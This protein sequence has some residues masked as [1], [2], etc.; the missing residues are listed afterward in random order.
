MALSTTFS[1]AMARPRTGLGILADLSAANLSAGFAAVLIYT[2]GPIPFYV[3]TASQLDPGGPAAVNGLFVAFATAGIGTIVLSLAFK[4]PLAIGWSMPGLIYMATVAPG[5]TLGEIVGANVLASLVIAVLGVSGLARRIT[6]AIPLSVVM[7]M[8]GGTM[9]A[10]C[11]SAVSAVEAAPLVAAP[12][13]AGYFAA[14]A[15]GKGWLPPV[16]GALLVGVPA[17]VLLGEAGAMGVHPGLP[18]LEPVGPSVN[19]GAIVPIAGPLVI[20]SLVGNAQGIAVLEANGYRT[21]IRA[22]TNM[23]AAMSLV[24]ALFAAPPASLQRAALATVAG[25]DAGEPR[26]RYIAAIVAS[27][28]AIALAFTATSATSFTSALPPEFMAVLVGLIM[29]TVALDAVRK[30]VGGTAPMAGFI[31]FAV[32]ASDVNAFGLGSAC[33]A[34]VA[35]VVAH[36]ALE[37][38]GRL[39][40]SRP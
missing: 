14:R 30:T 6:S 7:G 22:I 11:T 32:A 15:L 33:W 38:E 17:L 34:V 8:L 12:P 26:G 35:G 19:L 36:F 4:Q 21:P 31:A 2:F 16:A 18:G 23:T 37:R 10:Y 20:L 40:H 1:R 39:E 3:A 24:Q 5:H 28:G 9:L 13:I 25:D 29:L 27:V